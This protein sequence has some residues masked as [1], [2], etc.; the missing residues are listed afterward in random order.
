MNLKHYRFDL[1]RCSPTGVEFCKDGSNIDCGEV[2]EF[3]SQQEL[4][5][6][7]SEEIITMLKEGLE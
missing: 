2:L 4:L 5:Q 7:S 1:D 3:I 6:K